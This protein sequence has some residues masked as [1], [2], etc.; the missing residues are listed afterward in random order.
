M[1][2]PRFKDQWSDGMYDDNGIRVVARDRQ[3]EVVA[4]SMVF[5]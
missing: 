4:Y 5:S 2:N 1:V 3:D